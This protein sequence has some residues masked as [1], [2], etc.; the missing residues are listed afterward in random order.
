MVEE[1]D[2]RA[3]LVAGPCPQVLGQLSDGMVGEGDQIES[4]EHGGEII[5]AVTEIVLEVVALGLEDSLRRRA[6]VLSGP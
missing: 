1:S 3:G 4:D 5:F 6:R 2:A